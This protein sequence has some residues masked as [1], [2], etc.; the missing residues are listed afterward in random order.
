MVV[1][2]VGDS[3]DERDW[4]FILCRRKVC[5]QDMLDGVRT[6]RTAGQQN[7]KGTQIECRLGH[8]AKV[9]I[10]QRF[11]APSTTEVSN[12]QRQGIFT[13]GALAL[14]K[15][16]KISTEGCQ[17]HRWVRACLCEA[18]MLGGGRSSQRNLMWFCKTHRP[19]RGFVC[20]G[21]SS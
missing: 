4:R 3:Y 21:L 5:M 19:K 9:W 18:C 11:Y 2:A 14:I 15:T 17:G 16:T 7:D 12:S 8:G 20:D 13:C 10:S 1:R 6:D